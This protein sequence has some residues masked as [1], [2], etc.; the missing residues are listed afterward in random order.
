MSAI[1]QVEAPPVYDCEGYRKLL[2]AVERDEKG[3]HPRG[4]ER[5]S[6]A[7]AIARA[8][9]YAE[10][11][12]LTVEAILDA[13]EKRRDYWYMSFYQ[14][15][16]MPEIKDGSVRIFDT[17]PD[18]L[19]SIGSAGF[20]CPN[21]AGVSKSPYEC[22]SGKKAYGK[23]CDWKV[24]GLFGHMG[25]GITVF[26]KE[27]VAQEAM[28]LPIA[29]ELEAPPPAPEEVPPRPAKKT[30]TKKKPASERSKARYREYKASECSETFFEWLKIKEHNRKIG[31]RY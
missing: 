12:G 18:L 31:E 19:K 15:A 20:R 8:Q 30:P 7:W 23:T 25:K 3:P 21:C 14:E 10:K 16:N 24:Y 17:V 4:D 29:W 6:F 26:V 9:H 5:K 27:K 1:A 28:F 13:W 11:T 2:A 22:N